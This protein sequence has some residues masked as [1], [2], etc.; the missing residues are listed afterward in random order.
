MFKDPGV[1]FRW[2]ARVGMGRWEGERPQEAKVDWDPTE[3]RAQ[4]LQLVEQGAC[5][6]QPQAGCVARLDGAEG[7]LSRGPGQ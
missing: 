2:E 4:G 6:M 3:S 1:C 7:A 5:C